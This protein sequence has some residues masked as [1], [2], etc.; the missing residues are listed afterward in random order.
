MDTGNRLRCRIKWGDAEFEIEGVADSELNKKVND[1]C[2]IFMQT[3]SSGKMPRAGE[4]ITPTTRGDRR[5]GG[6]KPPFIKSAILNIIQKDPK[7]FVE[8][9][10]E[11]VTDKLKTE[12]GV[13]GANVS[14]VNVALIRLFTDGTL[15]RKESGGKYLYS[16]TALRTT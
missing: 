5:G 15:T 4:G 8:K 12:Y 13:P 11:D 7:W 16:I 14:P 2:D 1:L 6:R 9:S 3:I 10:S